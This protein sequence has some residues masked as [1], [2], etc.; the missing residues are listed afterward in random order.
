MWYPSLQL[1][2]TSS[3]TVK[4][5]PSRIPLKMS[6]G[7]EHDFSLKKKREVQIGNKDNKLETNE[8][9]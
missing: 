4:R 3:P 1:Y 8:N 9:E 7:S 5:Y 6:P 2:L